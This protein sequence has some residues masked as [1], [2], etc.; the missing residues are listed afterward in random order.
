MISLLTPR[1]EQGATMGVAQGVGSLAR[2]V[3]P[4]FAGSLF[5]THPALPYLICAVVLF[6]TGL[7][8][9]QYLRHA[10]PVTA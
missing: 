7:F 10:E 1:T 4:I 5:D 2:I 6:F 3:G 8:A 9:M